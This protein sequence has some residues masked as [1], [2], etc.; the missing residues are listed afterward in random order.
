M[1]GT[2]WKGRYRGQTQRWV[3]YRFLGDDSEIDLETA[4]PEFFAW[5][6][7]PIDRL[8]DLIVPFKRPLYEAVLN[9]FAHLIGP[10]KDRKD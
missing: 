4:H 5:K 3:C 8:V 9:E 6:W 10:E 1:N 2:V 7:A